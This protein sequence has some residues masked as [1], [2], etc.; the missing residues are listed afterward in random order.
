MYVH[1][2]WISQKDWIN[3]ILHNK[4]Q[5]NHRVNL[6]ILWLAP[7]IKYWWA[8]G[9]G[10]GGG[11][12]SDWFWL[13]PQYLRAHLVSLCAREGG[14]GVGASTQDF[15]LCAT[16]TAAL[17]GM[18][19]FYWDSDRGRS[20]SLVIRSLLRSIVEV[21]PPPSP[22]PPRRHVNLSISSSVI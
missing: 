13:R 1:G 18:G 8:C 11:G 6:G 17:A 15:Y 19:V 9:Q 7:D 5:T 4:K 20:S 22:P 21:I 14:K 10:G 2:Q 16:I 3:W 12:T